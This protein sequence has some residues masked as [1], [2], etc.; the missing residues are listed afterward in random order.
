VRRHACSFLTLPPLK[1]VSALTRPDSLSSLTFT[2]EHLIEEQHMKGPS[3][4]DNRHGEGSEIAQVHEYLLLEI[5][6]RSTLVEILDSE[7][8]GEDGSRH[9]CGIQLSSSGSIPASN[10]PKVTRSMTVG[11]PASLANG[12]TSGSQA[13]R[14]RYLQTLYW[15]A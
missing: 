4:P 11:M 2:G 15:I 6:D 14:G 7:A 12:A 8:L 5:I 13:G 10:C 3:V 1:H 9:G